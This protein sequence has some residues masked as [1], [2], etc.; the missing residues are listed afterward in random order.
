MLSVHDENCLAASYIKA[1]PTY[2]MSRDSPERKVY[3]IRS[4]C[5]HFL[6]SCEYEVLTR[7]N[8]CT[9]FPLNNDR[10]TI[11][12]RGLPLIPSNG[13][14][15]VVNTTWWTPTP[16][17]VCTTAPSLDCINGRLETAERSALKVIPQRY[18]KHS[19]LVITVHE[20]WS[21]KE[22]TGGLKNSFCLSQILE[23]YVLVRRVYT[24]QN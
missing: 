13:R 8:S 24:T 7:V 16:D 23:M 5:L 18:R 22:D 9:R 2:F 10:N 19:V 12:K 14:C 1:E 4:T 15:V 21:A 3:R 17:V 6:Q 20:I 11:E